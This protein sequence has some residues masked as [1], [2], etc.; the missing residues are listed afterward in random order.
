MALAAT[1]ETSAGSCHQHAFPSSAALPTLPFLLEVLDQASATLIAQ[2]VDILVGFA[3]GHGARGPR[4]A[5][6]RAPR[7]HGCSCGLRITSS[8]WS[9]S[10]RSVTSEHLLVGSLPVWIRE[11]MRGRPSVGLPR[12]TRP[13]IDASGGD[14][15]CVI[16]AAMGAW[17]ADPFENDDAADW[18]WGFE[19]LDGPAGLNVLDE[20][21][22]LPGDSDYVEAPEGSMAVAAAQLV[23][24]LVD[25]ADAVSSPY[26]ETALAW[27]QR[28][29]AGPPRS[30]VAAARQALLR[31]R[32]ANSELS[33]LWDE[34][35]GDEWASTIGRIDDALARAEAGDP[36]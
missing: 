12:R 21:L 7:N 20:A 25:P 3:G 36:G 32:S 26:N 16:T 19:D 15:S 2:L 28:A 22:A 24:W 6:R 34:E 17:G 27:V 5:H 9:H 8:T 31:V 33:E 1:H 30:T 4:H 29:S 13:L 11:R 18:A 14:A 10:T 23:A 35:G